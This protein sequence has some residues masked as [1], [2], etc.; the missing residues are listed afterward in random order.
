MNLHYLIVGGSSGLGLAYANYMEAQGTIITK[1]GRKS[2]DN[3]DFAVNLESFVE[4]KNSIS[5][6][7]EASGLIDSIIFCQRY[8]GGEQNPLEEY[9]VNALSISNIL[10]LAPS[11]F[12][13]RGLRT[14]VIISSLVASHPDL[15]TSL[16]Y[17]AS[18]GALNSIARF[19]ALKLA[20]LNIRV[21]TISPFFFVSDRN[22]EKYM[23]NHL[24]RSFI[25]KQLP[26]GKACK[27]E[28]LFPKITFLSN[29]D[30]SFITGQNIVV[31]GGSS[32]KVYPRMP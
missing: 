10:E 27:I 12:K 7:L 16:S 19:Y 15:S 2:G 26:L 8:R 18:K 17:Q 4:I 28:E 3:S 29:N 13:P 14:V 5:R 6:I 25:K 32:L 11:I 22:R 24:W 20:P 31:D 30:S 21:N 9:Q 1:L 23:K